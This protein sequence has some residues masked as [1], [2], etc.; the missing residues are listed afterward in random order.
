MGGASSESC[1]RDILLQRL[2]LIVQSTNVALD[3]VADRD[4]ADQSAVLHYRNMAKPTVRH[5]FHDVFDTGAF[6]DRD[7]PRCH[8]TRHSLLQRISASLRHG[9]NDVALGKNSENPTRRVGY[10]DGPNAFLC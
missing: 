8:V 6:I 4:D 9:A 5:R 7:D 10:H 2:S 3:D 1:R